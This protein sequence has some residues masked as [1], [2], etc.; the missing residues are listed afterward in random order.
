MN[1]KLAVIA[2]GWHYS[3]HFYE[4]I[5]NQHPVEGWEIDLF[6]IS[7][8]HPENEHTINEKNHYR[9][10]EG[11]D[12]L[13]YLDKVMYETPI[14]L[15]ELKDLGWK[16]VEK[17]NTIGDMEVFNQWS[18]DYSYSDY[19]VFLITHDDNLI[20]SKELFLDVLSKDIPLHKPIFESKY[21]VSG[22][23]FKTEI[24]SN[25]LEWMFL[26]NGYSEYISKAFTP[27]G[28]FSFYKK[29]LIDLLP[30]QKFPM[31]GITLTRENKVESTTYRELGA[32]NT[33]AGNFRNV[34]YDLNLVEKTNWLSSSKRVSK[35]CIE[36]ER[37]LISSNK[38][39]E[40]HYISSVK[41]LFDK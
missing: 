36:G 19:D 41:N 34:L 23:Q 13:L 1:K 12:P 27:R 31:D 15:K 35:Y 22:H 3:S 37:G 30:N 32:W 25:N 40:K 24:I 11:D 9:N 10:Y 39:G 6:I 2:S 4:E 26:D 14:T 7:H 38:C 5:A 17:P 29:E 18:E 21:G 8:R 20:L 33:N 28:S 16:Y